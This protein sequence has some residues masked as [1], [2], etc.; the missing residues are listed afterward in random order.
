M[1]T[2]GIST[3]TRN[4]DQ[5]IAAAARK[6]GA[7]AAGETPDA[8]LISDFAEALNAMVKQWQGTGIHIWRTTEA[9]LFLQLDQ[10]RYTLS[11][12]STDHAT[13]SF[14]ETAIGADEAS[15]QTALTVDSITGISSGDYVGVQLDDG[16][17]HWTTVNGAPS[18]TTVTLTVALTDSAAD[19]NLVVAYTTKLVRPLKVLSARRYN[20]SSLIDTPMVEM[21]RIEY[22]ELP[23]KTVEGT[24]TGFFYDRRGGANASG[25]FYTWPET[26]AVDDAIKMTVARPIQDFNAAGDDPDLPQEWIQALISNLAVTMA[27]EYDIPPVKYARL[28]KRAA[29]DLAEVTW[30]EE[31]LTEVQF[32]PDTRR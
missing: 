24:V 6:C 23:N 22:Q 12:T 17:M 9:T 25:L 16:T 29:I 21:D 1:T 19:G 28:E 27:D 4:R 18:G 8:D 31:E 10:V 7:I 11:S 3:F 2:S 26:S 20:F 30:G 32:I 13:E 5:I 14:V 15:G